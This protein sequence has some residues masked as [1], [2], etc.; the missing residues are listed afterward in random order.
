MKIDIHCHVVGNGKDIT[1]AD[2]DLYM[3]ADDNQ[4]LFTRML[5]NMVEEELE[6]QNSLNNS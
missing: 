2:E 6:K 5:A 4:L 1:K 3:N